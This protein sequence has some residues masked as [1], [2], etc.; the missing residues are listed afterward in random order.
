MKWNEKNL[1]LGGSQP[2][3]W[4]KAEI[5]SPLKLKLLQNETTLN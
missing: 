3:N 1:R 2:W 4:E 5:E